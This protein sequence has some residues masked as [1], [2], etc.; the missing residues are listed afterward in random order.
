MC[1][2]ESP[3]L[4]GVVHIV[5]L[6]FVAEPNHSC[7][8]EIF[9]MALPIIISESPLLNIGCINTIYTSIKYLPF[10]FVHNRCLVRFPM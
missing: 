8:F 5:P 4:L 6:T 10:L 9:L 1:F 2:L 3:K 7:Q